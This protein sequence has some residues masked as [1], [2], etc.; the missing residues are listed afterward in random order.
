M[1]PLCEIVSHRFCRGLMG[2]DMTLCAYA[3]WRR[4]RGGWCL[5]VLAFDRV[6]AVMSRTT[7]AAAVSGAVW[8]RSFE[9][10]GTLC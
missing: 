10:R 7:A 9:P 1:L 3:Q 4:G 5:W 2:W 8:V 6:F